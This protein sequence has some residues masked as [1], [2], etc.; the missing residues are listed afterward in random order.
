MHARQHEGPLVHV[1]VQIRGLTVF[2][3]DVGAVF[4]P[5]VRRLHQCK[6][7]LHHE[8]LRVSAA[9]EPQVRWLQGPS[10]LVLYSEECALDVP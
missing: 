5:Y 3:D 10:T 2:H 9:R 1:S 7:R 8:H 4:L 6:P